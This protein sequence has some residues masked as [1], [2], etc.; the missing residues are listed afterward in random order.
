MKKIMPITK[1][2]LPKGTHWTKDGRSYKAIQCS[3]D[4]SDNGWRWQPLNLEALEFGEL[5]EYDELF[6]FYLPQPRIEA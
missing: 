2:N 1:D 4:P 5:S 3:V 6:D